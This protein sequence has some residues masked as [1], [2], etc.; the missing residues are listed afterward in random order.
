MRKVTTRISTL[1]R[2]GHCLP[3]AVGSERYGKS[4]VQTRASASEV[5]WRLQLQGEGHAWKNEES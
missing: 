5:L 4:S 2:G 3:N 1:I